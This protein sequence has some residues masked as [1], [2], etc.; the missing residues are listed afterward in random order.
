MSCACPRSHSL[1][2]QRVTVLDSIEC[3]GSCCVIHSSWS[4]LQ[5]SVNQAAHV[6]LTLAHP[7]SA[8][9]ML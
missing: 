6:V 9:R 4:A 7:F 5:A 8:A 3:G 2:A 1:R